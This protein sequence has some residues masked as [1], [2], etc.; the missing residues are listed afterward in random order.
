M[1]KQSF[2]KF[3]DA[4]TNKKEAQARAE[5]VL[6]AINKYH[7][8]SKTILELG[9]GIGAVLVNFPKQYQL[10]GLDI[11]LEYVDICRKKIPKG[12]FYVMS[13][14]NFKLKNKFEIIFSVYDSINFLKK[15]N[16]W[17][18]TFKQVE[19]H[20]NKDGLFIFDMYTLKAL[21]DFKSKPANISKF[22]LG[23]IT[24]KPTIKRNTLIWNF[25]VFEQ[26]KND[27]YQLHEYK[28]K[29]SIY[30]IKKVNKA[31]SKHFQ[32]LDMKSLEEGRRVLI[33][34]RKKYKH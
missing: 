12:N 23:Y 15:F 8:N 26:L 11:K 30:S 24:D 6:K 28:F 16:H 33:V 20:L 25:N 2:T 14:H 34:C 18:S 1:A 29:E 31:L 19:I 13:M 22:H 7:K 9:T 27:Q 10:S 3:W 4:L 21:K 5:L 32:I 17:K